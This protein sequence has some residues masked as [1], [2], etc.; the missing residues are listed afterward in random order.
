MTVDVYSDSQQIQWRGKK[1]KN[2]NIFICWTVIHKI[3]GKVRDWK[4]CYR[5]ALVG[6]VNRDLHLLLYR[7]ECSVWF[8]H[9]KVYVS[10]SRFTCTSLC[11]T[12]VMSVSQHL[13]IYT[14]VSQWEG[15]CFFEVLYSL[16]LI[17]RRFHRMLQNARQ[18]SR[19]SA[20]ILSLFF[21]FCW[22]GSIFLKI[23]PVVRS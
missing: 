21:F 18:L 10:S 19:L 6:Y 4:M 23:F 1:M 5:D 9:D 20:Y 13:V 7:N 14:D 11:F 2:R 8:S 17:Q 22:V 16:W 12:G 3:A 15:S